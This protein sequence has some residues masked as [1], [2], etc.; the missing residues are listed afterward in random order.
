MAVIFKEQTHDIK[1]KPCHQLMS[2]CLPTEVWQT[3]VYPNSE[4]KYVEM[5]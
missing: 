3:A 4:V 2:E 1:Q 5:A